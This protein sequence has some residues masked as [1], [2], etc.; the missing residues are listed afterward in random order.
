[1]IKAD[2][3]IPVYFSSELTIRCV[4]SIIEHTDFDKIDIKVILVEDSGSTTNTELLRYFFKELNIYDKIDF[5]VHE[6]NAG[7]IEACYTGIQYRKSDYKLLLNSDTIV[8]KEWLNHMIDTAES[9]D[10]IAF[11]NPNTNQ[12]PN[13][14]VLMPPGHN[15]QTMWKFFND[16]VQQ[17]EDY[18]DLVTSTGFCLLIKSKYIEKFGFFDRIYDKGY[19]EESDLFFRYITQGLR[20]VLS[21]KAFVYHKGEA[22]FTDRSERWSLN[23]QILMSRY[24]SVH[25]GIIKEFNERTILNRLTKEL[26][27]QKNLDIDV[28]FIS[29]SNTLTNGG[30]KIIHN[31]CN[32]LNE[33]GISASMACGEIIESMELEDRLYMP[34][35]FKDI[36]RLDI[37]PK[38]LVFSLIYNAQQV[39][40]FIEYVKSIHIDYMPVIVHMMQDIESWFDGHNQSDL[41]VCSAIAG[42]KLIVSPFIKDSFEDTVNKDVDTELIKNSISL[43]FINT[44]ERSIDRPFTMC[45][46]L[47]KDQKRG[48]VIIVE[49][50][51]KVA[52][53]LKKEIQMITF[54]DYDKTPSDLP[55]IIFSNKSNISEREVC[56]ILKKSDLFIEASLF[57][58]YGMTSM[59]ALFSG[60]NV[61]SSYNQGAI[62]VLP[63]SEMVD[64]FQIGNVEELTQK[65]IDNI[66]VWDGK[67]KSLELNDV[68]NNSSRNI[69][70]MYFSYFDKLIK[71]PDKY[72]DK[73]PYRKFY[74]LERKLNSQKDFIRNK[75]ISYNNN[76]ILNN[77][78]ESHRILK[79]SKNF[80]NG[81]KRIVKNSNIIEELFYHD[82][83]VEEQDSVLHISGWCF[84][85][86]EDVSKI[87]IHYEKGNIIECLEVK[88][89][90]IRQD[91]LNHFQLE[92][93]LNSGF[94]VKIP[95][96]SITKW[97]N[98]LKL[99]FTIRNESHR[100]NVSDYIRD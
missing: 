9:D 72:I 39:A 71:N 7:F 23:Y 52:L 37:R 99:E 1:M 80:F 25:L 30:I 89:G 92:K 63:K 65:I 12:S 85:L 33:Y 61:I 40:E 53:S 44:S 38:V 18:L 98:S 28:L 17:K 27:E 43:D 69:F 87:E 60:C 34:I 14:H 46:M 3:I 58:G 26:N 97:R 76:I 86:L 82:I 77:L 100:L 29:P 68:F 75:K 11:V 4:Q 83:E 45:A 2:I 6:K 59:E 55:N 78:I 10:K 56:N 90:I 84:Y 42:S 47:R 57:Q 13:I 31:I 94:S 79:S 24:E 81:I 15:I 96:G 62:S 54:G 22:S 20:G 67:R 51:R 21:L 88:Y 32:G 93:A 5:I 66:K 36:F 35:L 74:Q 8:T 16:Q 70:Q 49:A 19:C 64:Y 95:I 48:A 91:V 50:L 73:N 41:E